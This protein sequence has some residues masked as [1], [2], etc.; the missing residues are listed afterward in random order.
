M[1]DMLRALKPASLP[2]PFASEQPVSRSGSV[3]GALPYHHN[4]SRR[5]RAPLELPFGQ[6]WS[7]VRMLEYI[8]LA[9]WI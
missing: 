1:R 7:K 9:S 5:T 8:A 3:R 4:D 6:S 2:S